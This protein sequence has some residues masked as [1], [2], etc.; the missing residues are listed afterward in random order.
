MNKAALEVEKTRDEIH[1][2]IQQIEEHLQPKSAHTDDDFGD[3]HEILA[4]VDNW[5]L[6]DHRQQTTHVQNRHNVQVGSHDNQQKPHGRF[7]VE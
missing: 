7:L 3:A 5:D 2:Q 4:D 6:R 1:S